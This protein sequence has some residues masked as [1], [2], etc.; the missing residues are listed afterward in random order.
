MR[1]HFYRFHR[2]NN[3]RRFNDYSKK[4]NYKRTFYLWNTFV[5]KHPLISAVTS[6]VLAIM[7]VR[8]YF[9]DFLMGKNLTEL[10]LW[11]MFFAVLFGLVGLIALK[12]WFRNNVSNRT[13]RHIIVS[14]KNR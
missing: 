6:I 4:F 5:R 10:R 14:S 7:L 11:F 8:L 12:V 2:N 1:R 13:T 3:H 9:L